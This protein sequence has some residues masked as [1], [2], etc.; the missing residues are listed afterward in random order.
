MSKRGL[1]AADKKTKLLELLHETRDFYQLKELE[2][3]APKMKGIVSQ[4]VKD[5]LQELCDDDSAQFDKIG[6]S[7]YFWAFPSSVTNVK[8][9]AL[10]AKKAE[11]AKEQSRIQALEEMV[12][13]LR[14][15]REEEDH[16]TSLLVEHAQLTSLSQSYQAELA[17][18]GDADPALYK[19]KVEAGR[20][21]KQEACRWT[22][23]VLIAMGWAKNRYGMEEE[24]LRQGLFDIGPT[25]EEDYS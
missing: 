20:I 14:R 16:R 18:Y 9:N 5:V 25:W 17:R 22:E 1:S 19:E 11:L 21:A 2:K 4:S 15:G 7:N 6:T 12:E 23:N 3:L 10:N 24:A 8:T 13:G